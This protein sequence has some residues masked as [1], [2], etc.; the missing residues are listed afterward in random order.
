M[1]NFPKKNKIP[2]YLIEFWTIILTHVR[3]LDDP[4]ERVRSLWLAQ[5]HKEA[6]GIDP[7][8]FTPD[9]YKNVIKQIYDTSNEE[10]NKFLLKK[11]LF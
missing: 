1:A 5:A 3:P 7:S 9:Y 8:M 10:C 11:G 2:S 6:S 4:A